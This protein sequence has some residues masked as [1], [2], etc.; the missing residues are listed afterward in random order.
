[1]AL[2]SANV[3]VRDGEIKQSGAS[4]SVSHRKRTAWAS[5]GGRIE[6]GRRMESEVVMSHLAESGNQR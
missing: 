1:M 4:L 3:A 2:F 5:T 6:E